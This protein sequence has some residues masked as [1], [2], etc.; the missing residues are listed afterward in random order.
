MDLKTNGPVAV[1]AQLSPMP[2]H[3]VPP[4]SAEPGF[5][6]RWTAWLLKGRAHEQRVRQK[7]WM[8]GGAAVVV[9]I[10][11]GVAYTLLR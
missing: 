6:A 3:L 10:G 7:T 4:V 2:I 1:A 5:E 9:A 11:V 8:L